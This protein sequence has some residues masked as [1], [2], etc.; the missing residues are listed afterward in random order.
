MYVIY[1]IVNVDTNDVNVG[2]V[3]SC[4][5]MGQL[6][7]NAKNTFKLKEIEG[8]TIP[9]HTT[10]FLLLL[11]DDERGLESVIHI[12]IEQIICI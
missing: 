1:T 3:L 11:Y 7:I 5:F 8:W 4:I 9:L 12:N 10:F 6:F 2:N